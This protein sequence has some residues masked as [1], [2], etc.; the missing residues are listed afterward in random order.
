MINKLKKLFLLLLILRAT[1]ILANDKLEYLFLEKR[2]ACSNELLFQCTQSLD[3]LWMENSL[4]LKDAI[5]ASL[6]I[7]PPEELE[8][9]NIYLENNA[10]AMGQ[11]FSTCGNEIAQLLKDENKTLL[12]YIKS[13]DQESLLAPNL[14]GRLMKIDQ[15]LFETI[16]HSKIE[17]DF[18]SINQLQQCMAKRL[19]SVVIASQAYCLGDFS[20]AY[21]NFK[22]FKIASKNLGKYLLINFNRHKNFNRISAPLYW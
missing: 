6:K 8:V 2:V 1:S 15:H 4:Y 11:Y 16:V 20:K 17:F 13:F 3:F 10:N 9:L 12:L 5:L 18:E 19:D 7:S 21:K 22:E 14:L